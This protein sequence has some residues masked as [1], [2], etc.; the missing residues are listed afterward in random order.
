MS[1]VGSEW[2][3][4]ATVKLAIRE[5]LRGGGLGKISRLTPA[6]PVGRPPT[7]PVP[8][9]DVVNPD[10]ET[11]DLAQTLLMLAFAAGAAL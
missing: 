11:Y 7:T 2:S 6:D 9:M 3:A 10:S 5:V 1:S 4:A 8:D